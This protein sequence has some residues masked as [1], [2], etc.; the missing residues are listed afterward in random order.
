MVYFFRSESLLTA[1]NSTSYQLAADV[2]SFLLDRWT[3][4]RYPGLPSDVLGLPLSPF[5]LCSGCF[6]C[7]TSGVV[8]Y[9][10]AP[11][12]FD[13]SSL[14]TPAVGLPAGMHV[15]DML[16]AWAEGIPDIPKHSVESQ[17]FNPMLQSLRVSSCFSDFSSSK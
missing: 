9:D 12:G 7:E 2:P 5:Q 8:G 14:T 15:S 11:K 4:P 13:M 1:P 17:R 6:M 3:N 10:V 16:P